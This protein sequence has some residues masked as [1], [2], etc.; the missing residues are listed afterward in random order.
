MQIYIFINSYSTNI[1]NFVDI[2]ETSTVTIM[3]H[4]D[5]KTVDRNYK[6]VI[7]NSFNQ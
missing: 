5:H 7:E 2:I 3:E 1:K 4:T 6:S